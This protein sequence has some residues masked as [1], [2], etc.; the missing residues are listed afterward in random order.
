MNEY[1][2]ALRLADTIQQL[3][4]LTKVTNEEAAKELRRL[5]EVNKELYEALEEV[6]R[7]SDRDHEAWVKAHAALA[8]ARG[9]G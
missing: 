3:S 4:C 2:E 1:S 5:H 6:V 9:E 7:I 8:K